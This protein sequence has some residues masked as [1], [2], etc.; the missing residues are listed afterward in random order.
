MA[1]ILNIPFINLW[2]WSNGTEYTRE[3]DNV[4]L[5]PELAKSDQRTDEDYD[6]HFKTSTSKGNGGKG[7]GKSTIKN[8]KVETL[9][10][11]KETKTQD[12]QEQKKEEERE[13]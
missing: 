7:K 11:T 13:I 5:T 10:N 1:K 2:K 8:I 4:V 3:D 9:A 12:K 6:K